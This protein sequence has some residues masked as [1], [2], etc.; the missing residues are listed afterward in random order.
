MLKST[1]HYYFPTCVRTLPRDIPLGEC[2]N[3]RADFRKKT[4]T[5]PNQYCL[6]RQAITTITAAI[7]N[8]PVNHHNIYASP[9]STQLSTVCAAMKASICSCEAAYSL[10]RAVSIMHSIPN[11][12][13][14]LRIPH[15]T[16][17][18]GYNHDPSST[19]RRGARSTRRSAIWLSARVD[20]TTNAETFHPAAERPRRAVSS[21]LLQWLTL[22]HEE[23]EPRAG[24]RK[25]VG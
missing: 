9:S 16:H 25:I 5:P 13:L 24:S 20:R 7:S 4:S 2:E 6:I 23:P 11:Q 22:P 8:S 18:D 1:V 17:V 3:I 15:H 12:I 10:N 21:K 19:C 14:P